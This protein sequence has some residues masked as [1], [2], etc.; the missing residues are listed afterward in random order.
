MA[1]P[2]VLVLWLACAGQVL[3]Q[4]INTVGPAVLPGGTVGV[5]YAQSMTASGPAPSTFVVSAGA[6]PAGVTLAAD[7]T[8]SGTPTTPASYNFTVSATDF[9]GC[10]GSRPYTV[11]IVAPLVTVSPATLAN[12]TAGAAYSQLVT[13]SGGT[14]PYTFAV[15][16]GSLPA[17]VTLAAGGALTGTPTTVGSAN[18][19]ITAT[20]AFGSTGVN[21][22][23]IAILAPTIVLAPTTLP[24]AQA[25]K[26][27]ARLLSASGGTGPYGFTVTSGSL[28]AGLALATNGNL[29]GTPTGPGVQA[30]TVTATDGNGFTG[31]RGYTLTVANGPLPTGASRT[32]TTQMGIPVQV[33]LTSGASGGPFTS[34]AVVAVGAGGSATVD[35][36]QVLTFTPAPGF[37]GNV[38]VDY[39][40]SN[41]WGASPVAS[42]LFVVDARPDPTADPDVIGLATG[43]D[44]SVR[45]FAETQTRHVDDR[46]DALHDLGPDLWGWWVSGTTR[47]GDRDADADGPA[48]DFQVDGFTIGGDYRPNGRF[49]FGGALG[50]DRSHDRVG[51]RGSRLGARA[52][53]AIGYGSFHPDL[54]FFLDGTVGHQR[55]TVHTLRALPQG[56]T[57]ADGERG[58]EQTFSSWSSG[59]RWKHKTWQLSAYGRLDAAQARLDGYA[60]DGDP[61]QALRYDEEA[62]ATRTRTLG[63]RGKFQHKTR[64]G[65]VEPRARVELLHDFHDLGGTW[66]QYVDQAD[67]PRYF[68]APQDEGGNRE[69]LELGVVFKTRL[70]TINLQYLG[71]YGGLY[72]NDRAFSVTFQNAR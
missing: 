66:V 55:I 70:L 52:T 40:L 37:L 69:V 56:T 16:A 51:D 15:S 8:L 25:G 14:A 46:L 2:M 30:F 47:G 18:F 67:G 32:I 34:A 62:I 9:S 60:E 12:A 4:C 3:A 28:P 6:L 39:T 10:L 31:S 53:S 63:V 58:G 42:I 43:V 65:L 59:Y 22:Y 1:W 11:A 64:W 5:P 7:G 17:G 20:D 54:P 33:D 44:A 38:Q 26:A 21:T 48:Q 45:I 68:V 57:L 72:D 19:T 13:A 49:A 24:A 36:N 50:Y 35:A 29:S 27:Y 61:T 71:M 23:K 41:T